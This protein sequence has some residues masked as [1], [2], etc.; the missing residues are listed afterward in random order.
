MAG[1]KEVEILVVDRVFTLER[2]EL[3]QAK[4]FGRQPSL[5]VAAYPGA[6]KVSCS[7]L[8]QMR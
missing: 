1:K 2:Y 3:E 7:K 8:G 4:G 5:V 6:V